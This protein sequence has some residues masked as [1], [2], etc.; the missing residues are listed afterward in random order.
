[1][2]ETS[3]N[4]TA[5]ATPPLAALVFWLEK[6]EPAAASK[7]LFAQ[8]IVSRHHIDPYGRPRI[9]SRGEMVLRVLAWSTVIGMAIGFGLVILF[10]LLSHPVA[11]KAQA[12]AGP[13]WI[14]SQEAKS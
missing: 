12:T 7:S 4:H 10:F 14:A 5:R 8:R 6:A 2:N 11:L 3:A 9:L 1:M 13:A